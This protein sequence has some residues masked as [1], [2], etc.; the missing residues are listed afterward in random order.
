MTVALGSMAMLCALLHSELPEAPRNLSSCWCCVYGLTELSC[1]AV[2]LL[3][4]LLEPTSSHASQLLGTEL[5]Q[6]WLV[7]SGAHMP[8]KPQAHPKVHPSPAE[9]SNACRVVRLVRAIRRGWIKLHQETKPEDDPPYLMWADDGQVL[10]SFTVNKMRS[11][12]L[13]C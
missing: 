11:Q 7:A 10:H 4:G 8:K 9:V 1:H 2:W 5:C 13:T 12:L 3:R 6:A